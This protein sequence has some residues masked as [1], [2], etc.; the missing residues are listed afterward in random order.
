MFTGHTAWYALLLDFIGSG[1]P[2][3]QPLFDF[4]FTSRRKLPETG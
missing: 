3:Q 2:Q 4:I 1:S